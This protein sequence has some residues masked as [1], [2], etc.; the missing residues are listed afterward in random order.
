V[1]RTADKIQFLTALCPSF[2]MPETFRACRAQVPRS[3]RRCTPRR[4]RPL[5]SVGICVSVS[6][7]AQQGPW[8][9]ASMEKRR[10]RQHTVAMP[11]PWRGEARAS[12]QR[13]CLCVCVCV[14]ACVHGVC[15]SSQGRPC[16]RA[17]A[18]CCCAC[19][20][21][22]VCR[23]ETGLTAHPQKPAEQAERGKKMVLRDLP[24]P[25]IF[26]TYL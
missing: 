1:G 20:L 23:C 21:R 26:A 13:V 3:V 2:S 14:R 10:W 16:S 22:S 7:H 11:R 19:L 17:T 15:G 25:N 18:I 4:C 24:P 8:R 5:T 6:A 9:G 12:G